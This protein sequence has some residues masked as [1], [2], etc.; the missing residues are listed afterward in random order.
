LKTAHPK[1]RE[2]RTIKRKETPLDCW[3][4]LKELQG[5]GSA[6]QHAYII[7]RNRIAEENYDIVD[8]LS[9]LMHYKHPE[10]SKEDLKSYAAN[11]LMDAIKKYDPS[12]GY[13]FETFATYRLF[14]SMYDE[15]RKST[16]SPRLVRQRQAILD[17]YKEKF[18]T[19]NGRQPTDNELIYILTE[20]G[21]EKPDKV[22]K[23]GTP[24]GL[25][26]IFIQDKN[27]HDSKDILLKTDDNTACS[28]TDA[29][30]RMFLEI[31][32][33][34]GVLAGRICSMIYAENMSKEEV[35]KKLGIDLSYVVK[36]HKKA[37]KKLKT[38]E[39]VRVLVNRA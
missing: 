37:L 31:S 6:F 33:E 5:A 12:K 39:Y 23:D 22:V 25:I 18:I 10:H 13:K 20:A 14:G 19:M 8:K 4:R 7:L 16:W 38:S 1:R 3:V 32:K 34:I 24:R 35:S 21:V 26:S 27:N 2:N 36:I 11:G 29:S 30:N 17:V 15:M 9:E 28:Q